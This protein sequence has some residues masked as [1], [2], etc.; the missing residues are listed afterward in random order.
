MLS[1]Q[2]QGGDA[3]RVVTVH[4]GDVCRSRLAVVFHGEGRRCA[5]G[6]PDAD[7]AVV[8]GLPHV[9]DEHFTVFASEGDLNFGVCELTEAGGQTVEVAVM[10][11]ISVGGDRDVY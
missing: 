5:A 3:G 11:L 8:V 4:R 7:E 2:L 10:G 1:G 6:Y 9:V